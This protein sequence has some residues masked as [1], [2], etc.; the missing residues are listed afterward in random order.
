M[1]DCDGHTVEELRELILR[2]RRERKHVL[3]A[4]ARSYAEDTHSIGRCRKL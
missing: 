2:C 3:R 4:Y 1:L